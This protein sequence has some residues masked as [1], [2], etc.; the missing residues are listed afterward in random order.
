MMIIRLYH[1]MQQTCIEYTY[2]ALE[3]DPDEGTRPHFIGRWY[4]PEGSTSDPWALGEQ[5][6]QG[7][8]YLEGYAGETAAE[9]L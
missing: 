4:A 9:F 2:S 6:A 5:I 1:V 3:G 8:E 7:L